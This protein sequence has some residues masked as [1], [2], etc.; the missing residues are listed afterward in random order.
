MPYTVVVVEDEPDTAEMLAEMMRLSGF[1]VVNIHGGE[2][3]ISLVSREKP[4]AIVLDLMM[5]DLSGL[6][7]IRFVR[8]DP[9]LNRIPVIVVSA[10]S[11][12]AQ[13]DAGFTAGA[14]AYL[15]KP[16]AFAALKGAVYQAI[17]SANQD[18]ASP[19]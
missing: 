9:R 11:L 16:V 17:Q 13:I 2:A 1:R 12:P 19:E 7:V 8:R 14:T 18:A 3:A 4:D 15:T 10:L 6:E 5:P